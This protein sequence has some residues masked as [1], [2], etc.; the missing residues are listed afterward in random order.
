MAALVNFLPWRD[1]RRR[2]RVRI[3]MWYAIGLV[4][5]LL[6]VTVTQRLARDAGEALVVVRMAADNQ[7]SAAL[8]QRES[9]LL[10]QQQQREQ[11]R[12]RQQ[13]RALTEVWHQRLQTIA[14][15]LPSQAWLTRLEY[16]PD[17]LTLSGRA[18]NLNAVAG[19]EQLLSAVSGFRPA[20]AG[21]TRRG[22]KGDWQFSFSLAGEHADASHR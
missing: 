18:L 4:L 14:T 19:A 20:R 13:R 21:E 5:A 11:R 7:L 17:A 16:Q 3:G 6:M 9:L 22:E 10:E 8:S 1:V 15:R 2:Q 12:Q